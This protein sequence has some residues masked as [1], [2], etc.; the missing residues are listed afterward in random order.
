MLPNNS[1]PNS[2]PKLLRVCDACLNSSETFEFRPPDLQSQS[3]PSVRR[4]K[5]FIK[6]GIS[7]SKPASILPRPPSLTNLLLGSQAQ[8]EAAPEATLKT[9]YAQACPT[10]KDSSLIGREDDEKSQA[11]TP[12][13]ETHASSPA[14]ALKGSSPQSIPAGDRRTSC[15]G[16]ELEASSYYQGLLQHEPAALRIL[17]RAAMDHPRSADAADSA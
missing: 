17:L 6:S 4:S 3:I 16:R 9:Q 13:V 10:K 2:K 8:S 7:D 11:E 15:G 12:V 14:M 5:T 1:G